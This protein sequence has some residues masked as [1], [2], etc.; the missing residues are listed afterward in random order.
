M[1]T[2]YFEKKYEMVE[3]GVQKRENLWSGH[4]IEQTVVFVG[5]GTSPAAQQRL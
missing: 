5:R 2:S 4:P 1:T 3:N